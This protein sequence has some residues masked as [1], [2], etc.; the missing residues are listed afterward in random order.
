MLKVLIPISLAAAL[1]TACG[2]SA[3]AATPTPTPTP[4]PAPVIDRSG[5]YTVNFTSGTGAAQFTAEEQL[6]LIDN[7][8]KLSGTLRVTKID[9]IATNP[10]PVTISGNRSNDG[11]VLNYSFPRKVQGNTVSITDT[12]TFDG[13]G[14][15]TRADTTDWTVVSQTVKKN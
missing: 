9:N 2:T 11:S 12:Y 4:T 1:I 8:G 6:Q 14:N 13:A 7:A 10:A 15:V 5:T 3:P